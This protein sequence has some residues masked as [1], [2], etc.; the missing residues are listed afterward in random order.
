MFRQIEFQHILVAV[1]KPA[2][3]TNHELNSFQK[4]PTMKTVNFC[5]VFPDV[6][7]VGFS[8]LGLKILYSILNNCSDAV[9]DRAYLPWV[10]FAEKLQSENLP[11]FGIESKI[12]LKSFDVVGFTLQS[13]LTFTNVLY[14]LE[15]AQIPVFAKDRNDDEPLIIGGGPSASN[16]LPLA[17]FF[18]AILIG[19]GEDAIIDIKNAIKLTKNLSRIKKLQK[20]S[21][22]EG[23]YV[24]QIHDSK[25]D[26]IS[27]RKFMDFNDSKKMHNNQLIPWVQPT[28]DRYVTEIMRGCTRG[29][30]FCH[31]GMF[32]RPTRE[33]D[34]KLIVDKIVEE[35]TNF[36]WEEVALTSLSSSD[37]TCIKPIILELYSRLKENN[38][39]LSLPSLRVDSIDEDLT[40]LLNAMRQTGLTIAPEAGSQRLRDIIN[41][42]ISEKEIMDGVQIAFQS[43][44]KTIKLYFMIGLPFEEE[45][46]IDAIGK[47]IQKIVD[48]VGKKIKINV[49]ISP[50]VPKPFT[51]F[52]W[53]K[54]EDRDALLRKANK[55]KSLFKNVRSVKI[56]YH[57]IEN[58]LL[59]TVL[60]RGDRKIGKLIYRAYKN[61]AKFD[62]WNEFF[63][64]S[65]WRKA[66]DEC[67][68]NFV[69]YLSAIE[70]RAE[71]FW[72]FIDLKISKKFLLEEWKN[73]ANIVLSGDCRTEKCTLCGVCEK[74][75][76]P[77]FTEKIELPRLDLTPRNKYGKGNFY[78]RVFYA[79]KSDMQFVAHLDMLRMVIRFLR[80]SKL[81]IAYSEGFNPHPKISFGPP[82]S[83]GVQGENEY[84]DFALSE[85]IAVARITTILTEK[86]PKIMAFKKVVSVPTKEMRAMEFYPFE[87]ITVTPPVDLYEIFKAK[88]EL[89]QNAE[90]WEFIRIRKGKKK[91]GDL[92]K[93][94]K[95]IDWQNCKLTIMKVR[96]GA[97]IYDVINAI[98]EI[99]RDST[100][101]FEIVR[102]ELLREI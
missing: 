49:T 73:A 23:L 14:A 83:T 102:D 77:S 29:C 92:K 36:G 7:E 79:K 81:P 19:D 74:D 22:I 64:F 89:F 68:I 86:L 78:Y 25:I 82:L 45:S 72:D 20:L 35:V 60:C 34:P 50:F 27:A 76:K 30:R 9:A 33:R 55:I 101:N 67:E 88:T 37:Y 28:H 48:F 85:S 66:A 24:P 42:N 40:K 10:D 39:T 15:L 32:Y 17:D 98:Y 57:T 21:E 91:T 93:I 59:E 38:A 97:G 2:R 69:D 18:D 71:L 80:V 94:V 90:K 56:K 58:S 52:Q 46:D 12:A 96:V 61:G 11:L 54:M 43:G 87:K 62:G 41:K 100:I 47:L 63:D 4:V 26:T 31:A 95:N 75:V 51:P 1:R 3:Y 65:F 8:H 99:E 6:Y 13:E 70:P 44:W 53:A 5:L 16:P 84:F